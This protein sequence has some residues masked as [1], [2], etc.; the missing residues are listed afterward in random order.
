MLKS[1]RAVDL[2]ADE[3]PERHVLKIQFDTDQA[4]AD[5]DLLAKAAERSLELRQ[6]L[7][8]LG[9]LGAHLRFVHV[10]LAPAVPATHSRHRLELG[11]R[12]AELALAVRAGDFDAL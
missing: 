12:L 10:E 5:L 11:D 3:L 8:D 9:D 4:L 7:L 1:V 6:R 2:L